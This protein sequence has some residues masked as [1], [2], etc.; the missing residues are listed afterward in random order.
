METRPSASFKISFSMFQKDK[1]LLYYF[2]LFK[3]VTY[4]FV[5]NNVALAWRE[6]NAFHIIEIIWYKLTSKV[7]FKTLLNSFTR[8]MLLMI[9]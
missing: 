3:C 6:D 8:K 5:S 1:F 4:F 9:Q 2:H 7:F